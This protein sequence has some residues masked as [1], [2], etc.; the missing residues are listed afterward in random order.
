MGRY[1]QG[2]WAAFANSSEVGR[3]WPTTRLG[4]NLGLELADLG[5]RNC[6]KKTTI[7]LSEVDYVCGV[8]DV[9]LDLQ[10]C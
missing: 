5:G 10:G 3:G 1:K 8:C 6:V 4:T 9:I 7:D 2:A